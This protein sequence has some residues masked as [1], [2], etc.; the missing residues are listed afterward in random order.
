MIRVAG[1]AFATAALLAFV[2]RRRRRRIH[3]DFE[4][5]YFAVD[6]E[7]RSDFVQ[8]TAQGELDRRKHGVVIHRGRCHCGKVA[9]EVDAPSDIVAFDCNCSN[10]AMRRNTH[11]VVNKSRMRILRGSDVLTCYRFGSG[12]ARHYF[13]SICGISPFYSP[14]SNPDGWAITA[15]CIA[16]G[17]MTGLTVKYFDGIH[18][19]D[20]IEKSG[21][22]AFSQ[23]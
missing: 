5:G 22:R 14:R 21:I 2:R 1:A 7:P 18:W 13:C 11:F 10:C 12:V 3:A 19:D 15:Q 4:G 20:Y 6:F 23:K 9:F 8:K 16:R 17:S